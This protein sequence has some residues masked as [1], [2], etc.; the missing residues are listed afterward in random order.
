MKDI[1]DNIDKL[2]AAIIVIGCIVLIAMGIDS[3]VKGILGVAAG[4]A[5]GR[6][7]QTMSTFLKGGS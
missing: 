6:G 3:D 5:F 7:A 4:W 2:I 1:I